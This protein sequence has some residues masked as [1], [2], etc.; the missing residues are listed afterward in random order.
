M[1][2][3]GTFHRYLIKYTVRGSDGFFWTDYRVWDIESKSIKDILEGAEYQAQEDSSSR[4]KKKVK[5]E[6]VDIKSFNLV[7]YVEK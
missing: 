3:T 7:D 2:V 4:L 6:D 5:L 1:G